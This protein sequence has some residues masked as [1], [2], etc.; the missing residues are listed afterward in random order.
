MFVVLSGCGGAEA[1]A[2]NHAEELCTCLTDAGLD[3]SL[4][5]LRLNDRSFMRDMEDKFQNE[6]PECAMKVFREMEKDLDDM[7][8]NQKKEY[9]KAFLK[10]CIDTDCADI[11]INMIPYDRMGMAVDMLEDQL[12][13][14]QR[15][16]R[17]R[18]RWEEEEMGDVD[19]L[20][21]LFR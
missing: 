7:S 8:K 13:R 2:E 1:K 21:D 14:Q 20:E 5:I 15:Y 17:D 19:D 18:N 12:R 6:V 9:T 3:N 11:A 4:N 10:A 16:R